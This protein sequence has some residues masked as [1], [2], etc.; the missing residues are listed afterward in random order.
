MHR[1]ERDR[2]VISM[3]SLT[4]EE[5][6]QDLMFMK[7]KMRMIITKTNENGVDVRDSG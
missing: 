5:R 2:V 4:V 6:L 1:R 7:K 3:T